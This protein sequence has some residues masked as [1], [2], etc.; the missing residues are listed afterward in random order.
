MP[1]V[2]EE[3]G[4]V[5]DGLLLVDMLCLVPTSHW[6]TRW[7]SNVSES[8]WSQNYSTCTFVPPPYPFK[9]FQREI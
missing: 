9:H 4:L 6:S 5:P 3:K 2:S 7:S 8:Q 1:V